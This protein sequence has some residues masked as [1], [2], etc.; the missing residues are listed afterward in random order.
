MQN[1]FRIA[2]EFGGYAENFLPNN[3]LSSMRTILKKLLGAVGF[4]VDNT[5][6]FVARV[7]EEAEE[8]F[9]TLIRAAQEDSEFRTQIVNLLSLDEFSR[10]SALNTF[11]EHLRLNQAPRDLASAVA[12]L[13][14]QNVAQK[15]LAILADN[16]SSEA[17]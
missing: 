4:R 2:S 11:L 3:K 8:A 5:P 13:L 6:S 14:D 9:V 17:G 7:P 12:I 1:Y 10:K 16:K 15:A